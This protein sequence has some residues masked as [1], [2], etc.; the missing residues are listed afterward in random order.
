MH[1]WQNDLDWLLRMA[2][3]PAEVPDV[4]RIDAER[5]FV[6]IDRND[7]EVEQLA[8]AHDFAGPFLTLLMETPAPRSLAEAEALAEALAAAAV[9]V[10]DAHE[11][12]RQRNEAPSPF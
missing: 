4:D 9:L 10:A 2:N 5:V 12:A 6:D 7:F 8:R 3:T 1:K 11:L